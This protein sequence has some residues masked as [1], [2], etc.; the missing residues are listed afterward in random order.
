MPEQHTETLKHVGDIASASAVVAYWLGLLA[1]IA[2]PVATIASAVWFIFR[3]IDAIQ[4]VLAKRK[5][6]RGVPEGR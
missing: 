1:G 3:A 4:V 6:R 2:A 5:G